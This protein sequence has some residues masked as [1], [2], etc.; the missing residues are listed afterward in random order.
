MGLLIRNG[1]VV[2]ADGRETIDVRCR[3]GRIV[4]LGAGLAPDGDEVIDAADRLVMPGGVDP[5]VHMALPVAGTVSSD[6]FASGTAAALAGGTTTIVDFVHPERGQPYLEALADRRREAATA[7]CD[8]GLHMAVTWWD[9]SVRRWLRRLIA[10][11]GVPTFKA[12]LAYQ[13][14]VGIDDDV[15][16][17]LMSELAAA[18]GR[19]LV[20]AEHGEMVELLRERFAAEG[21]TEPRY[22][23]LSRPPELEGEATWRAATLAGVTG[24]Q[25]YVV[26]VT[27]RDSVAAV[28]RAR[29]RGWPVRGETC[30]HYLLLDDSVYELPEFAGGAYVCA[31][32]L[33]PRGHQEELWQALAEGTLEVVATD[34]CPFT[35]E[36]KRLG[37]HDFRLIPGGLAGVEHRLSLLWTHGVAAGRMTAERFVDLVSTRPARLMGLYPRK[38]AVAVDSDADLVVWDP[39]ARAAIAAASHHQHCDHTPYE[40]FELRGLPAIV[41]A[42]GEVC[43][44]DGEL[45]AAAGR[46]RFLHRRLTD[47]AVPD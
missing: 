42:G 26:H 40:G 36:Q 13:A 43:C 34:H 47:T 21:H 32:P 44:R 2:T 30:T 5:H 12:Y 38:G 9:D 17:E 11:E 10:D 28:R 37:E 16:C 22:H 29:E 1:T 15:L 31:P 7:V 24:C 41:V 39:E 14:T 25:L 6:D 3:D 18:G 8:Y 27:C 46:G 23:A 35:R 33:R 45:L 19:L 20:H 4:E